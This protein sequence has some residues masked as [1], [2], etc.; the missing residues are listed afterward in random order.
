M[1]ELADDGDAMDG[2]FRIG[3]TCH[4][5]RFDSAEEASH[6]ALVSNLHD[7]GEASHVTKCAG[8]QRGWPGGA[9]LLAGCTWARLT[10]VWGVGT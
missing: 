8:R 3:R 1:S 6:H 4:H 9:G 10:A 2:T 7:G 5:G